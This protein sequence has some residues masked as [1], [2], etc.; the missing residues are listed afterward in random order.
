M[1]WWMGQWV[2]GGS[3]Y[4][5]KLSKNRTGQD[6]ES[7]PFKQVSGGLIFCGM[8]PLQRRQQTK[9]THQIT[10]LIYYDVTA[11]SVDLS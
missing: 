7:K 10:R 3:S 11:I 5:D 2:D 4:S 1:G 8:S 9:R 6:I